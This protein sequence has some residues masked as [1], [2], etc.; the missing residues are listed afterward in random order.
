[1]PC[2]NESTTSVYVIFL[3]AIKRVKFVS[4]N[5]NFEVSAG[6]IMVIMGPSGAG[7]S[8][9]LDSVLGRAPVRRGQVSV[10]GEDFTA[11]G[12]SELSA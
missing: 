7:K 6:E 12:L 2:L 1:M 5:I 4:K 8:T 3:S 10:N 9:L 11:N